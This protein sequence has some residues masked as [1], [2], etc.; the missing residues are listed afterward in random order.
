MTVDFINGKWTVTDGEGTILGRFDTRDEALKAAQRGQQTGGAGAP[1]PQHPAPMPPRGGM[2]FGAQP[3][4]QPQSGLG[5]SQPQG[6]GGGDTMSM[7][8][9][10]LSALMQGGG[11]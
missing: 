11:R 6:G 5:L 9:Q 7:I 1:P 2:G 4:Q 10:L 3:Q 8:A